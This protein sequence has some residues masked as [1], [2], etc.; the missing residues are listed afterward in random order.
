[1]WEASPQL[2][3]ALRA[4]VAL[5]IRADFQALLD[6]QVA[7]LRGVDVQTNRRA[8]AEAILA[9]GFDAVVLATGAT[10]RAMPGALTMEAALDDPAALGDHVVLE[11]RL[12]SFA[13]AGFIEWLAGSGRRVTLLAPSGTPAWQVNIYSGLAWRARLRDR[14]VHILPLHTAESLANGT[15]HMRELSTGEAV[16]LHGVTALIAP[17]HA[18][19]DD[20]LAAALQGQIDI[21]LAGDAAAAR[22]ALEAIFEGHGIGRNL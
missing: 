8:T 5:G 21:H 7:A 2:G 19:P 17:T 20:A 16:T 3:G 15:L 12:G 6:A 9:G 14:S 13:I 1:L 22:S 10:A 4:P 18:T 11:D